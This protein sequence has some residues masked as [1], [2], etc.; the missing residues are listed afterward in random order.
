M[1]TLNF[2]YSSLYANLGKNEKY[3]VKC[4]ISH[5]RERCWIDISRSFPYFAWLLRRV[6]FTFPKTRLKYKLK[7]KQST[8]EMSKPISQARNRENVCVLTHSSL[9]NM[10]PFQ[11][12]HSPFL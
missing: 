6:T 8:L 7:N 5:N 3:V 9:A 2:S 12:T 1:K 10:I 4:R 11:R